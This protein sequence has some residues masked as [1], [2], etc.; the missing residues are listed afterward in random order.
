VDGDVV[1]PGR[2]FP[3][4]VFVFGGVY[5]RP[6][7]IALPHEPGGC[8]D[9]FDPDDPPERQLNALHNVK[10]GGL[11]IPPHM[12]H[13]AAHRWFCGA[14]SSTAKHVEQPS[15]ARR[16][17]TGIHCAVTSGLVLKIP[18]PVHGWPPSPEDSEYPGTPHHTWFRTAAM[19]CPPGPC[20]P[21]GWRLKGDTSGQ[22]L[23]KGGFIPSV[24]TG[25]HNVQRRCNAGCMF[26]SPRPGIAVGGVQRL[27]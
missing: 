10:N 9:L 23:G 25:R 4:A 19:G 15:L 7:R 18:A 12:G 27:A 20:G 8:G 24:I 21:A 1:G 14:R 2:I 3:V 17:Q 16:D 13:R 11:V 6:C 22:T 5:D 26:L